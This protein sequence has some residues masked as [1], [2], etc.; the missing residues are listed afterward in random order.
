MSDDTAGIIWQ[1]FAPGAEPAA[2]LER[3]EGERLE[4]QVELRGDPRDA[5]TDEFAR[6]N[7]L[8]N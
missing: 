3:I 5:F 4:A 6:E 2:A 1:V 8:G 7:P